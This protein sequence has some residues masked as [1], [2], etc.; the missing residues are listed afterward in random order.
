MKNI[1]ALIV[2][3]MTF[4]FAQDKTLTDEQFKSLSCLYGWLTK[5]YLNNE[6]ETRCVISMRG[7]G[8]QG[9][10]EASHANVENPLG[11]ADVD[12]CDSRSMIHTCG[13]VEHGYALKALF[14]LS[15]TVIV[16]QPYKHGLYIQY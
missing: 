12:M 16:N 3:T 4:A 7:L 9:P 6:A 15:Q 5:S 10:W 13:L 2:L 11:K 14:L 8:T 1:I